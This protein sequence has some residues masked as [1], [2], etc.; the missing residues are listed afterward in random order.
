MAWREPT[1]SVT[2][3]NSATAL[4][5]GIVRNPYLTICWCAAYGRLI[6]RW[7]NLVYNH[8]KYSQSSSPQNFGYLSRGCEK[9]G[10]FLR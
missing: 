3:M 10:C 7:L 2:L 6:R 1:Y 5:G 8:L 9:D 4:T